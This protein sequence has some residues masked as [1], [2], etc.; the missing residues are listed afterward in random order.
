RLAN[1]GDVPVHVGGFQT[2]GRDEG[3]DVK[4]AC[5]GTGDRADVDMADCSGRN[6]GQDVFDLVVGNRC[7][8]GS[9]QDRDYIRGCSPTLLMAYES[10]IY[11]GTRLA[12]G[13]T[14]N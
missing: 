10:E 3:V 11:I 5:A 12:P 4:T 6:P 1:A 14:S 2:V 9:A 8:V 13:Y 7:T